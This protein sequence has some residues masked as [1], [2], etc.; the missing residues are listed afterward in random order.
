MF[1]RLFLVSLQNSAQDVF[2]EDIVFENTQGPI[3]FNTDKV[4]SGFLEGKNTY[5]R[6]YHMDRSTI[7][8]FE[9]ELFIPTLYY[10][11]LYHYE[12]TRKINPFKKVYEVYHQT[13]IVNVSFTQTQTF[14]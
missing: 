10:A 2:S 1:F 12:H 5:N 11:A 4:Y 8:K 6:N 7:F 9:K 13:I 3:S 14:K